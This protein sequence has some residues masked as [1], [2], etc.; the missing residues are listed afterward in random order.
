[1]AEAAAQVSN[2][3]WQKGVIAGSQSE[4]LAVPRPS[5]P[6]PL[7]FSFVTPS[8]DGVT[9]SPGLAARVLRATSVVSRIMLTA[10][11][12]QSVRGHCCDKFQSEHF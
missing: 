5:E 6:R 8:P 11:M 12:C 7:F 3:Q 10:G 4:V 1:M 9:S 2:P